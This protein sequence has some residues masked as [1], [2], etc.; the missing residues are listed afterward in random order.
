M[1][2]RRLS[3]YRKLEK[4][5]VDVRKNS[6]ITMSDQT[7]QCVPSLTAR[8]THWVC[9]VCGGVDTGIQA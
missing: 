2:Q 6:N 7:A 8:I 5:G 9:N 1:S 4:L 3:I